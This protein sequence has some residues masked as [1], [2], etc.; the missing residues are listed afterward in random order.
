[1]YLLCGDIHYISFCAVIVCASVLNLC[2]HAVSVFE[3]ATE[4]LSILCCSVVISS[5]VDV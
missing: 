4:V 3:E 2:R 1:M 5:F